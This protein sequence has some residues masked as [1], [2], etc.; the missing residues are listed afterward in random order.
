MSHVI[1]SNVRV[2]RHNQITEDL[3]ITRSQ[4]YN[5]HIYPWSDRVHTFSRKF[6]DCAVLVH[7]QRL[8]G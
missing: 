4:T 1:H 8:N 5:H 3:N 7:I 2:I 6:L